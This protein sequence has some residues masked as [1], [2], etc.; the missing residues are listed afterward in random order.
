MISFKTEPGESRLIAQIVDRSIKLAADLKLPN[1]NAAELSMDL[2][3][4]HC[5]GCRLRL[6]E[7]LAADDA[8]LGHD[9][10]GIRRH[11]NRS[12]GK[13]GDGFLPRFAEL[14]TAK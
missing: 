9:V 4:A 12:T 2:T 11:I 10:F 3:A 7:L 1:L 8:N 14:E 13:V 6:A 5:N